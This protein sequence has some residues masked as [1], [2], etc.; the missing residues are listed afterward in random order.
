LRARSGART[1]VTMDA[2]DN[3][4]G[5]FDATGEELLPTSDRPRVP[6]W[7]A[8]SLAALVVIGLFAWRLADSAEHQPRALPTPSNAVPTQSSSPATS[9]STAS[10]TRPHPSC[11]RGDTCQV[12]ASVPADVLAAVRRQIPQAR[13]TPVGQST[14]VDATTGRLQARR[15]TVTGRGFELIVTVSTTGS[16]QPSTANLTL[17]N[18]YHVAFSC[19][20]PPAR[21]PTRGQLRLIAL[22]PRLL[23]LR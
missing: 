8:I 18:G 10:P 3:R 17:P 21:C 9:P 19:S 22:D 16:H 23:R 20:G 14:T 2:R 1:V 7:L 13:F 6:T 11:P 12:R 15:I 5:R 4:G